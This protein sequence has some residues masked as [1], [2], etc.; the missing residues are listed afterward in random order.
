MATII[1]GS[2]VN[3]QMFKCYNCG[4]KTVSLGY[5]LFEDNVKRANVEDD[6]LEDSG[7]TEKLEIL[8][9]LQEDWMATCANCGWSDN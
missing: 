5:S 3:S 9:G 4:H 8:E 1:S 2:K 6:D 7:V